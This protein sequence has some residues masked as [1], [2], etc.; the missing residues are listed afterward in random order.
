VKRILLLVCIFL[1]ACQV[2]PGAATTIPPT[3]PATTTTEAQFP[4][5]PVPS[6]PTAVPTI[7]AAVIELEG[8]ELPPG[9]S[10]IKYAD[11]PR[12]TAFAFD[13]AG[14]LYV[15]SQDGNV[16]LL[17]DSNQDGRA[18]T[19]SIFASGFEFP[20]GVAVQSS[21]ADVYVS[22]QGVLSVL[23]DG[24]HDDVTD[25]ERILAG[26]LPFGMHQND[27]IVFGPD[28]W[29]YVGVGSAC[30]ACDDTNPQSASILR[31]NVQTGDRE[32]YATGMRNPYGIAFDPKTGDL[33]A[34]D[35]GRDDLGMDAPLEELNHIVQ[36]GDYG[37]P[38]CWN[39][40]DQP[41]CENTI[42]SIAGFEAHS[43][44]DAVSI[45]DG[46]NFPA[47]Y[48]GNAFVTIF[49]SWLKGGVQTGIQRAVLV[50]QGDT[51]Q[52]QTSWFVHFPQG[53]MP[54]PLVVGPDGALYV[55]DY[56]AGVIYRISYG[57]P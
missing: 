55:G 27:N 3:I 39:E 32:I 42:P 52:A 6:T 51:Y 43:S 7:P 44:A 54:L 12:P 22:H 15:T 53:V 33:F 17:T 50:P 37:Y 19:T 26:D 24:N 25:G 35:N 2:V 36:G 34:T 45:Y 9:F 49:G 1:A 57:Y 13:A 46:Q 16:Y 29:L 20:L 41:G 30:N 21:T 38:N 10:L 40:Q 23:S 56:I 31:F 8:A 11:L 5:S 28:G 4:A 47:E 48:Q 14:R 18:D